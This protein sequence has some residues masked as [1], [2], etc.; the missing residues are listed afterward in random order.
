MALKING[1]YGKRD[2]FHNTALKAEAYEN[3][4]GEWINE[5]HNLAIVIARLTERHVLAGNTV[6]F[7]QRFLEAWLRK[8]GACPVW[9]YHVLDVPTYAAAYLKAKFGDVD[10]EPPFKSHNVSAALGVDKP[11]N[12]HTAIDDARWSKAMWEACQE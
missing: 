8:N 4:T 10:L 12:Q 3:T 5:H 11:E 7:D 9:D 1:Y 6:H 2:I